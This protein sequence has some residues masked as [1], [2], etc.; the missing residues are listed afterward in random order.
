LTEIPEHLLERSRARRAAL[1]LGGGDAGAAPAPAASAS[2]ESAPAEGKAAAPAKA[3]A[4]APAVATKAPE[5]ELSPYAKAALARKKIPFWAVPVLLF[6]PLWGF[7]YWGTLDPAPEK[8]AGIAVEGAT[9]YQ[10]CASCHGAGGTGGVG[11]E[12]QTVAQTFSNYKDH[13]WWVTNGSA[14]A[15][16]GSPYGDADR[17]GGQRVAKGG[18]P[19]WGAALSAKDLLSVVYYERSHFGQA[20]EAELAE[21]KAI[22]ANPALPAHFDEGSTPEDIAAQLESLIPAGFTPPAG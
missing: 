14:G 22:Q 13:V 12:L 5:I 19:P 15:G 18:M 9:V 3:A 17:P 7:L 10:K 21:L 4:A 6:L 8:A 20:T 16:T 11:P 1:G 2:G